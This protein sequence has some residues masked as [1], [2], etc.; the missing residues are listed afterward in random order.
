MRP[1]TTALSTLLCIAL[2]SGCEAQPSTSS[3]GGGSPYPHADTDAAAGFLDT[4]DLSSASK[5]G[6]RTSLNADS[7]V[8][9]LVQPDQPGDGTFELTEE[10]C[11]LRLVQVSAAAVNATFTGD[12]V[13]NSITVLLTFRGVEPPVQRLDAQ[14]GVND[15][16]G[17][18]G[19]LG[20]LFADDDGRQTFVV[21]RGVGLI[22]QL[23]YSELTC[24]PG[25]DAVEVYARSVAPRVGIFT[26]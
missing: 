3:R 20:R 19:A 14:W 1:M 5:V 9:V 8:L 7:S 12:D 16:A 4:A 21:A 23:F 2:L 15:N 24:A 6:F 11:S 26:E 17:Q 13:K 25:V 22:S 18:L 10:Q